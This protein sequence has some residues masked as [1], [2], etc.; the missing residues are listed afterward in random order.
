MSKV[1][2]HF[3][4]YYMVLNLVMYT[5]C[6]NS[7][8]FNISYIAN[9]N[10]LSYSECSYS[11]AIKSDKISIDKISKVDVIINTEW[12]NII[13]KNYVEDLNFS[14]NDVQINGKVSIDNDGSSEI[15]ENLKHLDF[16]EKI[17][18]T[19]NDGSVVE[20]KLN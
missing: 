7:A 2:R 3:L 13:T 20:E 5:S 9:V 1:T 19:L 8:D 15:S 16:I 11:I 18:V 6:S 17:N 14:D 4:F 10:A 12:E